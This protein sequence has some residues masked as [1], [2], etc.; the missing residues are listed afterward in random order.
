VGIEEPILGMAEEL[1]CE[2]VVLRLP[3]HLVTHTVNDGEWARGSGANWLQ[4]A[5]RGG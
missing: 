4:Q 1:I 3:P 5:V 2:A